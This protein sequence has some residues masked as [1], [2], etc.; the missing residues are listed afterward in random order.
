MTTEQPA[1]AYRWLPRV[2]LLTAL[3][4][5]TIFGMAIVIVQMWREIGPLRHDVGRLRTEQGLIVLEDK[6]RVHAIQLQALDENVWK[7]RVY[8]PS[9]ATCRLYLAVNDIP[10]KGLPDFPRGAR[11]TVL[12][13][14]GDKIY[15]DLKEGEHVLTVG[16]YHNQRGV[17]CVGF[18][19]QGPGAPPL[20][21]VKQY[22]K[23]KWPRSKSDYANLSGV[24]RRTRMADSSGELVLI[25]YRKTESPRGPW[26]ESDGGPNTDGFLMWLEPVK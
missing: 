2:S 6:T 3:L 19:R 11:S 20:S 9:E 24:D 16:V 14:A 10:A 25:R 23:E 8:V 22:E 15:A 17:A 1:S 5:M 7:Y 18:E 4:M 13:Y 26:G 12:G 21:S